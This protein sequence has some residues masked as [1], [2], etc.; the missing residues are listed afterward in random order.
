MPT[1]FANDAGDHACPYNNF[2]PCLGSK[3][4]AWTWQGPRADRC[5]TDNLVETEEGPR[6]IGSPA[7]PEGEGWE[8]DG[9]PFSKGYHRS[10]KDKLPKA[11]GQRWS[12]P[13]PVVKGSCS[14]HSGDNEYGW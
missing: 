6:P 7:T 2:N 1:I 11:T 12:R 13:R 9:P 3:C 4:M 10:D 14:R 8:M 5:E